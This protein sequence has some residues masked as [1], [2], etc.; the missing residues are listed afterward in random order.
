MTMHRSHHDD[1]PELRVLSLVLAF[2]AGAAM[3]VI[4]H[5]LRHDDTLKQVQARTAE[6]IE[7]GEMARSIAHHA[8]NRAAAC[9]DE[10]ASVRAAQPRPDLSDLLEM[11]HGR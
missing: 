3:M 5:D 4:A 10:L 6:A 2:A 1:A 8:V 11:H 9:M 7:D